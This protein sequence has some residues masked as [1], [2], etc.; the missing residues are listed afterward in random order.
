MKTMN[1]IIMRATLLIVCTVFS[2]PSLSQNSQYVFAKKAFER[3]MIDYNNDRFTEALPNLKKAAMAGISGAYGP[4][5]NL[6]ADGDYDGSGKGNYKEAFSWLLMAQHKY[7][8]E[9]SKDKELAVICLLNF[10]PLCFLTGDYQ[11]TIEHVSK[12]YKNGIPKN[13]YFMAQV[14]A[15]YLKLGKTSK[16]NE[17]LNDAMQLAMEKDEMISIHTINAIRSKI[18]LD[19]K[20]YSHALE[21]SKD[22][23]SEGKVPLADYVYG[24]AL[25]ETKNHPE[26]GQRWVKAAAEYDYNGI[27]EINCFENEIKWYWDTIK[28][29]SF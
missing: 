18:A 24:V 3:G 5:I 17:W 7:L 20:D 25:I 28:H 15:S 19:K 22:A 29:L 1:K 13:S 8:S 26:I 12:A 11:G 27:I 9:G 14:A 4:I 2:I 21:L 16:A 23:A 6:Y 10:D